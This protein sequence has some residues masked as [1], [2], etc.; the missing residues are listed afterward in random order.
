[1]IKISH[2]DENCK[3][4][5]KGVISGKAEGK[6]CPADNIT[7]EEI[8]KMICDAFGIE[9]KNDVSIFR[10]A[11]GKWFEGYVN[12]AYNKNIIR[13]IDAENFGAGML[14]TREDIVVILARTV[15]ADAE[16]EPRFEDSAQASEYARNAIFALSQ[17]GVISGYPDGSFKP[18]NSM[19]RAEAAV[20]IYN[21]LNIYA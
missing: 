4:Y 15:G 6:F 17:K 20:V 1:M 21:L 19:T 9:K 7:R 2:I 18:K 13:G 10:D 14:A 8:V 5:K 16:G 11:E 12:A 3:L